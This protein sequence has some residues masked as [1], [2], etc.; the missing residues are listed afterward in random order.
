M[1]CTIIHPQQI[2]GLIYQVEKGYIADLCQGAN[3]SSIGRRTPV[4]ALAIMRIW[5][6]VSLMAIQFTTT[7]RQKAWKLK[8]S[9]ETLEKQLQDHWDELKVRLKKNTLDLHVSKRP[10]LL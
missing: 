6:L 4:A 5:V 1:A 2:N 10:E 7:S 9:Y 8:V 3:Y